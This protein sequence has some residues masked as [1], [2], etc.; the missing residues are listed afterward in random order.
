MVIGID[1]SRATRRE[2]TGT[3]WY[4]LHV[5]RLMVRRS[6]TVRFVLYLDAL[7]EPELQDL[8]P[9]VT[10][11]ILR[12]PP[13]FLWSQLR[14]SWE[15][16]RRRPD[17]LFVPAHTMPIVHPRRTVVTLHD[18]GFERHPEL[19]GTRHIGRGFVG[20]VLNIVARIV[21]LG[22]YGAT[23]F[24]Y[25]RWSA[26]FAARHATRLI[27]VS[28]FTKS[29]I[30][31]CY[32]LAQD[33]IAV[34]PHGFDPAVFRRPSDAAIRSTQSH[35]ALQH[36]YILFVGRLER[37][38]NI[39]HLIDVLHEARRRSPTLELVLIGTPGLGW[40][41]AET[42]IHSHKLERAVHR[43]GWQPPAVYRDLLAGA[44]ALI[45]L[46][47][48]EGFGMPVL[49]SFAV[50]TPVIIARAASLPEIAGHAAL[51]VPPNDSIA[52]ADAIRSVLDEQGQRRSL[53]ARGTERLTAFSWERTADATMA[54]LRSVHAE[55]T[56]RSRVAPNR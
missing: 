50:G 36:P 31:D 27:T 37:K 35:F 43:L 2:R 17:V 49:E 40:S 4:S 51:V 41:E 46:S 28:E 30:I 53:I 11:R 18:V 32:R 5:T 7:P 55:L 23:E 29:E 47:Q 6:P 52:A 10:L 21:T 39:A 16:I 54:V 26:R 20:V 14:L 1:A 45:F 44:R 19:Y 22:R 3:E 56:D 12:W 13:R 33:H 34:I 9:N 48:Y 25:H 24:D 38:K 15:M 42:R 8:G